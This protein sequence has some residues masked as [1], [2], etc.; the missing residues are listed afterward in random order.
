MNIIH[1]ERIA[2]FKGLSDAELSVVSPI[3]EQ[4]RF[5]AGHAVLS[6]GADGEDMYI[7]TAGRVRIVKSMLLKGLDL[8]GHEP[9]KVLATLSAEGY[10]VF[11]EMALIDDAPRSATVETLEP[12]VFLRTTRSRFFEL[13]AAHPALGC[14]LLTAVSMRLAGMVRTSNSEVVKLTTALAL[15]LQGNR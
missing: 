5:D 7:L 14:T 13:T 12:S 9:R 15:L 6:E 10:P 11:G 8:M 2:L 1:W 3:F 4:V